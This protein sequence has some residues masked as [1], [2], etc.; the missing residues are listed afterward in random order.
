MLAFGA[1]FIIF[2]AA[3]VFVAS[4]AVDLRDVL[5]G[6]LSASDPA[7]ILVQAVGFVCSTIT[8]YVARRRLDRRTFVSLGLTPGGSWLR[9]ILLGALLGI[10]LQAGIFATELA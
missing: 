3:A 9:E 5:R 1:L 8:V 2:Q 10:G 6:P 7:T 4:L